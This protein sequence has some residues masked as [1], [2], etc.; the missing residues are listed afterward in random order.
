MERQREPVANDSSTWKV[1]E[2]AAMLSD[3]QQ[4]REIPKELLHSFRSRYRD[5]SAE[6][7]AQLFGFMLRDMEIQPKEIEAP[8]RA[9]LAGVDNGPVAWTR[10]LTDLR[11]SLESPR[12]KVFRRFI[13]ISGGIKFVLDLRADILAAKP[14]SA[15]ALEPL[16]EEFS[17][18]LN[19][20][21][22]QGFLYLQEITRDSSFRQI[23]YLT[24]HDLVHP[25]QSLE[26]IWYRLGEDRRCFS[27][28]H[29][30]MPEEPIVFIEVALT[31][32]IARS[33]HEILEPDEKRSGSANWDSAVFYSINN[34]QTGL[35][36]MG[37][38][39][40]LISEVV[41]AIRQSHREI[42]T[43]CTLSP[44]PGFRHR[45]L[46]P[47]LERQETNF[48]MTRDLLLGRFSQSSRR[49][50]TERYGALTGEEEP[51]FASVLSKILAT[52][53]WIEDHV[54]ADLLR[55]PLKELTHFYL[56]YEK[57]RHGRP[58]N[59]VADFHLSNGASVGYKS[60][61]FGANRSERGL[62][63]ACGMM[64]NYLYSK[65]WFSRFHRE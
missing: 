45:Y 47:I 54:Y 43:F 9:A 20:W 16:D 4:K 33:I 29:R 25:M 11:R 22:Q 3:I 14:T 35:A 6:E 1:S 5:L 50:L 24:Q 8:L 49:K 57:D 46:K 23:R 42:K 30:A 62:E 21:F 48:R 26:E 40:M 53:K 44:I 39:R 59:P 51:D 31:H 37:L 13:G 60:V 38:A 55:R 15:I 58:L 7:K 28:N 63:D 61:N 34:T 10:Q 65:S 32:G 52:P 41:D 17:H 56:R 12:M 19:S 18:L 2:L 27:L 36:G 64:V